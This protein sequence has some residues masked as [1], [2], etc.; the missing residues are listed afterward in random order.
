MYKQNRDYLKLE[1]LNDMSFAGKYNMPK[2]DATQIIPNNLIPFNE[3][4]RCESPEKYFV[5]F[6]IDDYQFER[7]WNFPKR[8]LDIL[9]DFA[10]VISPDF[11]MYLDMPQAQQIWNN[12]R[13]KL[14]A[15]FL[16]NNGVSV[17]PNVSW[18]DSNSFEFCFDGMPQNSVVAISTNGCINNYSSLYFLDGY[19]EMLKRLKPTKVLVYGKVPKEIDSD[20][21][22]HYPSKLENIITKEKK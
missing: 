15:S 18:S 20:L 1:L 6:Y 11:S 16:Q 17:I 7:L 2:L 19:N 14:L 8:Y 22:I 3:C 13:S 9:K 12:Y 5:H 21:I 10:G 4:L